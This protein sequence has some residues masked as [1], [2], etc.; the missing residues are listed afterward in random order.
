M[1]KQNSI[2]KPK[3]STGRLDNLCLEG[4]KLGIN[5]HEKNIGQSGTWD[6]YGDLITNIIQAHVPNR[7]VEIPDMIKA[8]A[9]ALGLI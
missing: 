1:S 3:S 2:E 9:K 5:R 6:R 4:I 7:P 8:A